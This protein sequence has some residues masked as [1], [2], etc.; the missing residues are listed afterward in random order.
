MDELKAGYIKWRDS[1]PV[2][3]KMSR[4][5]EGS[6]PTREDCGDLDKTTWPADPN[7]VAVDPWQ[8]TNTLPMRCP[9]TGQEF[10]F[11]TGS[12]G[13]IGAVG[14][15]SM[16]YGRQRHGHDGELPLIE[17]GAS[18]YRHKTYG[19]VHVPSFKIVGWLSEVGLI[20]GTPDITELDDE[21]PF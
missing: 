8:A 13:G 17:L 16:S 5:V 10:V 19:E 2:D 1:E 21:I 20:S 12:Q 14:K 6:T 4:V 15:L 7:G 3:E 18:S 11:T 9:E